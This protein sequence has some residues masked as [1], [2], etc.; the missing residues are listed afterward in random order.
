MVH[1]LKTPISAAE[2][3]VTCDGVPGTARKV[4]QSQNISGLSESIMD[5]IPRIPHIS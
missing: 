2:I 5:K 4:R 3:V 1:S